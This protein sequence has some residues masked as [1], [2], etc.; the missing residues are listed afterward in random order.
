MARVLVIDDKAPVRE[1]IRIG[2]EMA[3]HTV[4]EAVDGQDGLDR[5]QGD[6]FDLVIADVV[7][8]RMDG[9]E[10]VKAVRARYPDLPVLTISGG[11]GAMP[12][13]YS[14]KMTEMFG[15][16]GV[17]FKPFTPDELLESVNRLLG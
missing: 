7:M 15:A 13:A 16:G 2:L 17:L 4:E 12:A 14:L 5:V 10:F 11:G 6:H 3:G 8:P 1:T 9:I